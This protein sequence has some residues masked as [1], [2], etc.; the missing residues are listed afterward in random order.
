MTTSGRA[1][2]AAV[3]AA[4]FAL[5]LFWGTNFL[6]IR[7]AAESMPPFLMMGVRSLLA[8]VLLFA[9]ARFREGARPAPGQWGRAAAVGVVLFVGCHGLLA[10][11]EQTVPSGIAA[12]VLATIPVWMTLLDWAFGGPRPRWQDAVGLALGVGGLGLL[13]G[14]G[15]SNG[16]PL[17]GLLALVWSA[18]AWAAGSILARRMSRP[19]NVTLASGMQLLCGGAALV[20]A[21]L[22]LGESARVDARVLAPRALLSFAYMVAISSLVGFTAYM[23]LLRVA[24][25]TLVG[26]Y[27]FVNPVVALVVGASAAGETLSSRVLGASFVIVSGVALI[28][29]GARRPGKEEDR[30]RTRLEGEGE[31][32]AGGRLPRVPEGDG[33]A[34]LPAHAG[35]PRGFDP[36][37]DR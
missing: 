5:Y 37:P 4:L 23:W 8:G 29:V 15:A 31:G 16:A 9:W 10:W 6:A 36:A 13:V 12:L 7:W 30:D 22:L 17:A 21:G 32:R 28:V 25:P 11:A 20:L 1:T 27:A 35:E 33:P 26:T 19:E 18:F 3:W 14:P 24:S 2:T 34:A